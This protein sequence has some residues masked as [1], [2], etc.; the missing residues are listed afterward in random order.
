MFDQIDFFSEGRGIVH[1]GNDFGIIDATGD[2][3]AEPRFR[4]AV[5]PAGRPNGP[6]ITVFQD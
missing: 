5:R 2:W 4:S 1:E 6:A 3:I